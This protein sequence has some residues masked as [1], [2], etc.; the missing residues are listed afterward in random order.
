MDQTAGDMKHRESTNP[1]KQEKDK[2][3]HPNTHFVASIWCN[4]V[5]P[6]ENFI[7]PLKR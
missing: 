6:G 3:D 5:T 2:K 7:N 1:S 4:Q